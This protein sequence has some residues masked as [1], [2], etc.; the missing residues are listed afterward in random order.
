MP[1][2]AAYAAATVFSQT[3]GHVRSPDYAAFQ[4]SGYEFDPDDKAEITKGS[5]AG[6]VVD[7]RSIKGNE[8]LVIFSLLGA[9]REMQIGLDSLAKVAT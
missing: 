2:R 5:L 6:Q 1:C 3:R 4:Q 8:G 9:P 7:L